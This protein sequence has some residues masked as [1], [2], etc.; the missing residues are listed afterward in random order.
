MMYY[1]RV[2]SRLHVREGVRDAIKFTCEKHKAKGTF[3]FA[4]GAPS[5]SEK[6]SPIPSHHFVEIIRG[7][8]YLYFHCVV[9]AI[10]NR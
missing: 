6:N 5:P 3:F 9:L 8:S 2:A 10:G 7:V 1:L 4:L